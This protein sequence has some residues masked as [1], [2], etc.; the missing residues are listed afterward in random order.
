MELITWKDEYSVK[1]SQ[2]D[3][4]H[5][6]LFRMVNELHEAMANKQ[7]K[8]IL[9]KLLAN[10]VSYTE[11]HF[12]AEEKFLQERQYPGLHNHRQQHLELTGK[13]KAFKQ[14]FESGQTMLSISLM[15]FLKDWLITHILKTD[16]QY[17]A[18]CSQSA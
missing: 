11:V 14:Q 8:E 16:M 1:V 3:T 17:A 9:Q 5:K 10:L 2:L 12:A 15:S 7:G 13:V 6:I 18:F 4:Q